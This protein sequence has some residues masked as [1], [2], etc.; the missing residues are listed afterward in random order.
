[1][2]RDSG[3]E[4][5]K[6]RIAVV[7]GATGGIGQAIVERFVAEGAIVIATGSSG[8]EQ[9]LTGPGRFYLQ[10]RSPESFLSWLV[11]KLPTQRE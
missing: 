2:M 1:M 9:Q 7:I 4:R 11:P 5:L 3:M 6:G 8:R 10:T